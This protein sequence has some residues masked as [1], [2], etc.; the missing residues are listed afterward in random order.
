V[1]AFYLGGNMVV[2]SPTMHV[3]D[4]S[5]IALRVGVG[6]PDDCEGSAV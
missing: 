2:S 4:V 1:V 5:E 3:T 6:D